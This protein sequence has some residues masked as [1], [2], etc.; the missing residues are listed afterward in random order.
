MPTVIPAS[1]ASANFQST[2]PAGGSTGGFWLDTSTG[3]LYFWNGSAWV[4][5]VIDI[6]T[7]GGIEADIGTTKG[8]IIAFSAASTPVRVAVGA[9][10]TVLQANSAVAAGVEFVSVGAVGDATGWVLL[11]QLAGADAAD[12]AITFSGF[13]AYDEYRVLGRNLRTA[14]GASVRDI[15]VQ[16][17]ADTGT[18]YNDNGTASQVSIQVGTM[19]DS[20]VSRRAHMDVWIGCDSAIGATVTSVSGAG[21][22]P[23]LFGGSWATAAQ[24]SQIKF[25]SALNGWE[26]AAELHLYGRNIA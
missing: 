5:V 26:G 25:I 23:A 11:D 8:D 15:D 6:A 20:G 13:D 12:G 10:G 19:P 22:A 2:A 17:N 21:G 24:V 4:E 3:V 16:F 7:A 9:D 18:N 1:I 14:A